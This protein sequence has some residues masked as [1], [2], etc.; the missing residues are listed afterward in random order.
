[1]QDEKEE[2]ETVTE[3]VLQENPDDGSTNM[4]ESDAIIVGGGGHGDMRLRYPHTMPSNMAHSTTTQK[5]NVMAITPPPVDEI[6]ENFEKSTA[7][8]RRGN[9][10]YGSGYGGGYGSY[11]NF[12]PQVPAKTARRF[13]WVETTSP[14]GAVDG[15]AVLLTERVIVD[16]EDTS[17][18][19]PEHV[20]H[21]VGKDVAKTLADPQNTIVGKWKPDGISHEHPQSPSPLTAAVATIQNN[22]NNN[23]DS[24]RGNDVRGGNEN[25]VSSCAEL[26]TGVQ[27][28]GYT[29]PF[30]G[31]TD[32]AKPNEVLSRDDDGGANDRHGGKKLKVPDANTVTAKSDHLQQKYVANVRGPQ[33]KPADLHERVRKWFSRSSKSLV[34]KGQEGEGVTSKAAN[35]RRDESDPA[36]RAVSAQAKPGQVLCGTEA[37][38]SL[39]RRHLT[40]PGPGSGPVSG[41]GSGLRTGPET[42][43]ATTQAIGANDPGPRARWKVQ[44]QVA[45]ATTA[46][47]RADPPVPKQS[48]GDGNGIANATMSGRGRQ[49]GVLQPQRTGGR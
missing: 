1:M 4:A 45:G 28:A 26:D 46:G 48:Q 36:T 23:N 16:E 49:C 25:L 10:G 20:R 27:S 44:A 12:H 24:S 32:H 18:P 39:G 34:G 22:N 43:P 30:P 17:C 2:E 11:A 37:R 41:H 21:P 7:A 35:S 13:S 47:M 14:R 29:G 8:L 9:S 31:A 15:R 42:V 40:G 3:R 19:P 38:D 6:H 5:A 33:K